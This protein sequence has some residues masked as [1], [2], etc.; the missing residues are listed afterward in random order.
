[1]PEI[2]S[3]LRFIF[4]SAFLLRASVQDLKER[5]IDDASWKGLLIVSVFL[6]VF[7]ARNAKLTYAFLRLL[8]LLASAG[9][10]SFSL[11]RLGI[12]STGDSKIIFALS[13]L[14]PS[15]PD[16]KFVFPAFFLSVFSNAVILTLAAPLYFFITNMK[17]TRTK[18]IK[19]NSLKDVLRLFVG[20]YK[21][22][23]DIGKF[24]A[25][26]EGKIFLRVNEPKL[27][28]KAAEIEGN[29][30][31]IFVTPALP[32]VVFIFYGFLVSV[33]YG[34]LIYFVLR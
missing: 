23:E 10:L 7:E 8:L 3:F 24:E 17:K 6:A 33:F 26:L 1:M 22:R 19:I 2:F 21:E 14:F 27:F 25:V 20:Y 30:K 5:E 32:F 34:D 12:M 15:L 18:E 29:P 16:G 13:V 4:G 31:S 28:E 11:S 9:I